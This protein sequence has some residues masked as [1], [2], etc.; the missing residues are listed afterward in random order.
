MNHPA[1]RPPAA[2]HHLSIADVERD[3]GL[4]KDTLRVWERRYGFPQPRRDAAGD[5]VYPL[6][7]V[8]RLRH[9]RR[10]LDAGYRP[11]KV[12][13]L[14]PDALE[15]LAL[16]A[17]ASFAARGDSGARGGMAPVGQPVGA[18]AEAEVLES[19]LALVARH[20]VQLLRQA[21]GQDALRIGL[22]RFIIDRVAP[23]TT[24][25]GEAWMQG[26][27][28]VFE[29]HLYT[30]CLSG[31]LR[32]AIA[33]IP[34]QPGGG[35]PRV[36]LTTVPHEAHGLGLLMVEAL[37]ALEQCECLSLGTQTPLDD[38][39]RAAE[40]HGA[41]IVAL[42][43]TAALPGKA[44]VAALRSLRRQLPARTAIWV[45]G[46]CPALYQRPLPGVLATPLLQELG[47]QVARWRQDAQAQAQAQGQVGQ[48]AAGPT[49]A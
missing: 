22:A 4:P 8:Q 44:A 23:L 47:N 35:S 20:E 15:A 7:Q 40:A 25:V 43:F 17:P 37:L 45:G 3:T 16:Q 14:A 26:R 48:Q 33:S 13:A 39:V 28:Q 30:E 24:A 38:I 29:E 10:L 19:Y 27:F 32:Q 34:L 49:P 21:L 42:S 6:E 11:G 12:V 41:D 31:V 36:L 5:R 46:Q 18:E 1:A 9:I 2:A